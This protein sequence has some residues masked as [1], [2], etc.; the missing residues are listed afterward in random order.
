LPSSLLSRGL[1][2]DAV[3]DLPGQTRGGSGRLLTL[4]GWL[5]GPLLAGYFLFDKAFAYMRLPGTP[6]YVGEMVLFVGA[7]GCLAATG[8][9]RVAV[10]DDPALA[11]LA[12]FFLW[13]LIRFLPGL[14]V[15]HINAVRD[16]ALVYYCLFAFFIAAALARSPEILER[17]IVQLSRLVPWLLLWLPIAVIL[18]RTVSTGPNVPFSAT[19]L[20]THKPGDAAIAALVALG[21]LWLFPAGR[22]ARSRGLWSI[23][24]LIVFALV[25]TQNRGG[26]ISAVAGIAVG[27]AFFRD[28][29]RLIVRAA[30]ATALLIGAGT[31]LSVQIAGSAASQGRA[32]SASQLFANVESIAGAHVSGNQ[33]GTVQGR[34]QL[35][36]E[37]IHKQVSQDKLVDGYGFGPNL[38]YLVGGVAAEGSTTDPL[39]SPHNSHLDILA[40]MGLV[41]M[42][43]WIALW[44]GWYW[45]LFTG[46]RRLAQRGL[47]TRR[48]VA[49]LCL[50]AVTATLVNS[51]FDPQLE[52]AHAAVLLWV[53]FG[54]GV[55]VTSFRAWFGDRDLQVSDRAPVGAADILLARAGAPPMSHPHRDSAVAQSAKW[56]EY[57]EQ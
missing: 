10:R 3:V 16:F 6:L 4:F 55:A 7:L 15:Y 56:R 22:S 26:L 37:T 18:G 1:S 9:L 46:C 39:R 48:R 52:G 20:A 45:R 12:A 24:A 36:S 2:A 30:A 29:R 49:V 14:R 28:R 50:M 17:L 44:V 13:G 54:I 8:Y 57:S 34:T 25:A 31:L 23:V 43:L 47:Y 51:F 40:R 35:W 11:L 32:F 53:A 27:L 33:N 41:G 5:V 19:P 21:A 38:A 42:S